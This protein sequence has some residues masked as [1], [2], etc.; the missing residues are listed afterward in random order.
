MVG[1]KRLVWG[2]LMAALLISACAHES[3]QRFVRK[4]EITGNEEVGDSAIRDGLETRTISWWPFA[5]RV[6]FDEL[7]WQRD[8][9]RAETFYKT[10]GFFDARV[11]AEEVVVAGPRR[12]DINLTIEE[13]PQ[14]LVESVRVTPLESHTVL[15]KATRRLLSMEGQPFDQSKYVEARDLLAQAWKDKGYCESKVT[16]K[17]VVDRQRQTIT[18]EANAT[19]GPQCFIRSVLMRGDIDVGSDIILRHSRLEKGMLVTPNHLRKAEHSIYALGLFSLVRLEINR[20]GETADRPQHYRGKARLELRERPLPPDVGPHKGVT[21]S[22]YVQRRPPREVKAG[23]GFGFDRASQQVRTT[24]GWSHRNFLGGLRTL[25]VSGLVGYNFIP[26]VWDRAAHGPSAQ[27]EVRFIQPGFLSPALT[28]QANASYNLAF[29]EAFQYHAPSARIGLERPFYW[30]LKASIAFEVTYYDFFNVK[31]AVRNAESN[32][33]RSDFRDP[34]LLTLVTEAVEWDARD[35]PLVTRNGA[36]ARL[37]TSQALSALG[38]DFQFLKVEGDLRGYYSPWRWL[39]LAGRALN[40]YAWGFGDGGAVPI[41]SRYFAGGA[42]SVRGFDY[43]RLSPYAEQCYDSGKCERV[44]VGG[45][46]IATTTLESRFH[47]G[48]GLSTVLFSDVGNV[49]EEAFRLAPEDLTWNAGLGL[50]Y[51]TPVGPARLDF[52]YRLSD[53]ERFAHLARWTFYITLGEAF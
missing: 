35:N 6:P 33:L 28:F 24:G 43:Q 10:R 27:A 20:R 31:S 37:S 1:M 12:V 52:A 9:N 48:W 38:S 42:N 19:P 26:E 25:S 41:T 16:G 44:P 53:P 15:G 14:Y 36:Y 3:D 29:E 21:I 30:D 23:V 18:I 46:T 7:A 11:T 17:V 50:R 39:T 40:G 49:D 45:L 47:V 5:K 22:L 8:L 2:P 34:F 51:L 13:G 4:I 32:P